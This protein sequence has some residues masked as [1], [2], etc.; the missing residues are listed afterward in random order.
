MNE[1]FIDAVEQWFVTM[2][3]WQTSQREVNE[4]LTKAVAA[5][6]ARENLQSTTIKVMQEHIL[7]L[8]KRIEE[9]EERT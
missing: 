3:E 5:M 6:Q 4:H 1:E 8:E 9:L 2:K 7:T